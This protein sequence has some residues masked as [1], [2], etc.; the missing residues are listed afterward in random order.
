M[1]DRGVAASC[2]RTKR[3][4]SGTFSTFVTR[5]QE[6]GKPGV[7]VPGFTFKQTS[8]L[9]ICRR[10]GKFTAGHAASFPVTLWSQ[11]Q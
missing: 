3:L 2:F 6:K 9:F 10:L 11:L 7:F 5:D 4:Q 1:P 8:S